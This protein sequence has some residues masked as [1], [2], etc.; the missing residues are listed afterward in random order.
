MLWDVGR[1]TVFVCQLK[2][3]RDA[4]VNRPLVYWGVAA[5]AVAVVIGVVVFFQ[6][7]SPDT[8]PT[9]AQPTVVD[10]PQPPQSAEVEADPV[11]HPSSPEFDIVRVDETGNVVIAGRATPDCTI[12]VRDGDTVVGTATVDR[13]GDWVVLPDEPL[14]PGDRELNLFAECSDAPPV[15]SDRVVVLAVPEKGG[16]TLAVAVA[17]DGSSPTKVLQTPAGGPPLADGSVPTKVLQTPAGG[18]PL[19]DGSVPTKVLQTPAGGPPLADGSVPTKV[20][21]TPAGGPP[22][23]DGSVPEVAVAAVDYDD[24]GEVALSGTAPPESTVQ[25]YVDNELIGRSTADKQGRW[26]LKPDRKVDPGTYTLRVDQVKPDGTV[27]ARTQIPFV[28]G[29]PL[30]NLPPGRVVIIQPGDYLWRIARERYG[31]GPQYT[32]IY[33]A[34]RSQIRDPDLIFPGQVFM[35]PTVN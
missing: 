2:V 20:L 26:T 21:Q 3:S 14:R 32:L 19:A 4:N 6:L 12:I 27:V 25:V 17:R 8:P 13:R 31:A 9:Q 18:P 1:N 22:L 15:E 10:P 7:P 16:G 11:A 24:A 35:V 5:L 28:R 23:A 30:T 34:N 33:E 29:E